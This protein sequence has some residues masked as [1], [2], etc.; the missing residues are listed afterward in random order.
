MK[1]K[2]GDLVLVDA[3]AIGDGIAHTGVVEDITTF[4]HTT[5]VYIHFHDLSPLGINGVTLTN[6]E[7][8]K[9]VPL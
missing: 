3:S 2:I 5:F 4:L 7:L 9:K 1:L 6:L 8:I